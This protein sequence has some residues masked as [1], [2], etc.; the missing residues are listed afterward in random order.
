MNIAYLGKNPNK[1]LY[2]NLI[3]NEIKKTFRVYKKLLK[4]LI[5]LYEEDTIYNAI[6]SIYLIGNSI[7]CPTDGL[8]G[9]ILRTLEYG[10]SHIKSYHILSYSTKKVLKEVNNNEPII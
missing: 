8:N 10:A 1:N 9:K 2:L 3:K 4:S 5:D 6:D 7:Y